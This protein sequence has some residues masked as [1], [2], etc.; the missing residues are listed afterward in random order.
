LIYDFLCI[1]VFWSKK[2]KKLIFRKIFCLLKIWAF[3]KYWKLLW[4]KKNLKAQILWRQK[5][6]RKNDFSAF[7]NQKKLK[8]I[9]SRRTKVVRNMKTHFLRPKVS[10][11]NHCFFSP[12]PQTLPTSTRFWVSIWMI[13]YSTICLFLVRIW[14]VNMKNG[15]NCQGFWKKQYFVS[16]NRDK[17]RFPSIFWTF[18]LRALISPPRISKTRSCLQLWKVT[19]PH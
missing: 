8:Y 18:K 19:F 5:I 13:L 15:K 7:L 14:V 9:K 2:A 3:R 12:G 11:K 17:T 4:W 1:L 16:K 6:F 10:E